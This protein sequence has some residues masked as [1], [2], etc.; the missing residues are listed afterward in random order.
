VRYWLK[1]VPLLLLDPHNR[2]FALI[3]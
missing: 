1:M 3:L 2:R